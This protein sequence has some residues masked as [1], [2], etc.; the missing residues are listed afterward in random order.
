MMTVKKRQNEVQMFPAYREKKHR[1]TQS[2]YNCWRNPT[3]A[4]AVMYRDFPCPDL[5]RRADTETHSQNTQ[6]AEGV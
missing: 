2:A 5:N 6:A 1:P 3:V 4:M